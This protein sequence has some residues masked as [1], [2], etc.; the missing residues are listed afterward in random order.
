[1]KKEAWKKQ[2]LLHLPD[3]VI[4]LLGSNLGECYRMAAGSTFVKKLQSI[5]WDGL[6]GKAFSNGWISWNLRDL[7]AGV[8]IAVLFRLLVYI[9]S[10]EQKKFRRNEE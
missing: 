10:E 4:A 6:L 9:K 8:I 5:V 7:F 3:F 1:M 2:L